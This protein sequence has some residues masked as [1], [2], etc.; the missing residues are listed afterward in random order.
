MIDFIK[1]HIAWADMSSQKDIDVVAVGHAL[2]DMRFIVNKFA[3]VDEEVDIVEQNNGPGGSAVNVAIVVAKLGGRSAI[4]AKIG[5]DAFGR[6]IM[7]ELMKNKVDVSGMRI[8][9]GSTGFSIL[10]IDRQGNIMLYSFKGCAEALGPE[11]V[12]ERVLSRG[13][14][15]H[16][17]SLRPDTSLRVAIKA[18]EYDSMVSWDPGRR[19]SAM[20]IGTFKRLLKMVDIIELNTNE[21]GSL[22]GTRNPVECAQQLTKTGPSTIIV[23]MGGMGVY[24]VNDE[25]TGYIPAFKVEN[26]R[27]TTGSGDVFAAA[28]LLRLSRGDR[29]KDALIYAQAAAALKVTML[30][31][32]AIPAPEEIERFLKEHRDQVESSITP[33]PPA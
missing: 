24:A 17:A 2:M 25:F 11:E 18:K 26:I 5:L 4:L 27:D 12:D 30:G 6:S 16:I 7:E 8:G 9:F 28:L 20:G 1:H 33:T 29:L 15:I 19:L 10:I 22:V 31:A 3:T 14:F 21:C 13:R 32:H 23:K